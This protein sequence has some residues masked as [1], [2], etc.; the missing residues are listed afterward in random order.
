MHKDYRFSS[1]VYN[2]YFAITLT[3]NMI[4]IYYH[5]KRRTKANGTA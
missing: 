1:Y 2:Y 5:E 4:K 3:G